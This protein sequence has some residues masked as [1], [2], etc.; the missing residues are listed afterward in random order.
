MTRIIWC[1]VMV[2]PLVCLSQDPSEQL[3]IQ[4]ELDQGINEDQGSLDLSSETMA[5]LL[6]NPVKVNFA[7]AE[8]LARLMVLD[9][10]QISNLLQYREETGPIFTAYELMVIKGFDRDLIESLIPFLDFTAKPAKREIK[11]SDLRYFRHEIILRYHQTLQRRAGFRTDEPNSYTGPPFGSMLRYRGQL[12]DFLYLGITAQNDPGESFGGNHN[13][14]IADHF[15]GFVCLSDMGRLKQLILGDYQ[16]SYGQGLGLWSNGG[17]SGSG[18]FSQVVR[19]GQGV[20]P[21]A[22]SEENRYLRGAALRIEPFPS[23]EL[24]VFAS[25]K[26]IDARL[27]TD[28]AGNPSGNTGSLIS[29]G[30]HRTK[31]EIASKNTNRLSM[32][33]GMLEWRKKQFAVKVQSVHYH[34]TKP[35]PAASDLYNQFRFN[36]VYLS[37]HGIEIRHFWRR[38]NLYGEL[39]LDHRGNKA[40]TTGVE[41]LLADGFNIGFGFR[42]FDLEY[43]SFFS[44]PPAVKG[45]AGESGLFVGIDWEIAARCKLSLS[46]DRYHYK[47][48]SYRL[49]APLEGSNSLINI[50]IPINRYWK[51]NISARSRRGALNHPGNGPMNDIRRRVRHYFRIDTRYQ[52]SPLSWLS[53]R[54]EKSY[55]LAGAKIGGLLIYQDFGQQLP[56]AKLDFVMRLA[57][58]DVTDFQARIYAYESDL[59]YRF[60][61]PAY[62]GK[63]IRTYFRIKWK[64]QEKINLEGKVSA[65]KYFDRNQ[66]SSGLQA[67]EGSLFSDV[68]LQ[69]RF[70]F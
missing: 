62:H 36:G 50:Q 51:L 41:A 21:Y 43:M 35:V 9:I 23:V 45:S 55:V 30:L 34:F 44:A 48:I 67:I 49:D 63:A 7:N 13:P 60:S 40:L 20:R 46:L 56:A 69:V 2:L 8:E 64:L 12:K 32:Y 59:L 52:L 1:L 37:N 33:G 28:S 61:V 68:S 6:A 58:M 22:G 70:K 18:R 29:S 66:I 24:E 47:W 17:F 3:R 16:V 26:K 65:T 38:Y 15:S 19:Y 14:A 31:S 57:L 39:V 53:W 10:F 27:E 54:V 5:L 25:S 4:M 11:I 42:K